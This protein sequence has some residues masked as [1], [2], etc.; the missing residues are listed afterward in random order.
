MNSLIRFLKRA[1]KSDHRHRTVRRPLDLAALDAAEAIS[2]LSIERWPA[3]GRGRTLAQMHE[4]R[5]NNGEG[6]QYGA[7]HY[8]IYTTLSK[9]VNMRKLFAP[10]VT[11]RQRDACSASRR[12]NRARGAGRP[13]ARAARTRRSSSS[14]SGDPPGSDEPPGP[15][16]AG[17]RSEQLVRIRVAIATGTVAA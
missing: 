12:P 6:P 13:K 9:P 7:G 8:C 11:P 14:S 1:T 3:S 17:R 2:P 4:W 16:W 10:P 15:S 5:R